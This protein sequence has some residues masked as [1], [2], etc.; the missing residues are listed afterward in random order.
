[1]EYVCIERVVSRLWWRSCSIL[2][3]RKM[4]KYIANKK[5]RC[6]KTCNYKP[7]SYGKNTEFE[8]PVKAQLHAPNSAPTITNSHRNSSLND[9]VERSKFFCMFSAANRPI[10][11]SKLVLAVHSAV[12]PAMRS[13]MRPAVRHPSQIY[14]QKFMKNADAKLQAPQYQTLKGLS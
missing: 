6:R 4:R 10:M 12:V 9:L 8:F 1:M 11:R 2:F 7:L 13:A 14:K 5:N 3:S